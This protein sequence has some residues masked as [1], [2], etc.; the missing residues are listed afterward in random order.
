MDS[1]DR[2]KG[3][4]PSQIHSSLPMLPG[5]VTIASATQPAT[6]GQLQTSPIHLDEP[7]N[8]PFN[9]WKQ[10]YQQLGAREPSLIASFEGFLQKHYGFHRLSPTNDDFITKIVESSIEKNEA[11]QLIPS[12][13]RER[14]YSIRKAGENVIRTILWAN[15]FISAAI[16]SQPYAALAWSGVSVLLPVS[17]LQQSQAV[18]G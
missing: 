16:S 8:P 5:S 12:I 6:D 17:D 13:R 3:Q 2:L 10:A 18:I 4:T 11:R 15:D 7:G 9:L 1:S 14:R